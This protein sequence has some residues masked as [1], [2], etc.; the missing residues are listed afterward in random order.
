MKNLRRIVLDLANE[1]I[2]VSDIKSR[3]Q[4]IEYI[5]KLETDLLDLH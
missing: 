5:S 4:Q 1:V 2:N 3:N